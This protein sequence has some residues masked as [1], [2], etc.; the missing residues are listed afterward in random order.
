MSYKRLTFA[1]VIT[2]KLFA[3]R[4]LDRPARRA[5]GEPTACLH[6]ASTVALGSKFP[7]LLGVSAIGDHQGSLA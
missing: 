7:M 4:L 6:A 1:S 2:F 3:Q 5:L